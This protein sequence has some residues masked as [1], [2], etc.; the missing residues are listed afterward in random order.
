MARKKQTKSTKRK[1]KK[2]RTKIAKVIQ[3]S[4]KKV[5]K[6][7]KLDADFNYG[8]IQFLGYVVHQYNPLERWGRYRFV[9]F[10]I[11]VEAKDEKEAKIKI[12]TMFGKREKG[13]GEDVS[14]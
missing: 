14:Y 6:K 5:I 11:E 8:D 7:K 1:Y 2:T 10:D 9:K 3:T 12:F 4:S 13:G